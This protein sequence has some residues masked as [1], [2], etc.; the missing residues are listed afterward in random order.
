MNTNEL[1][2]K[3]KDHTLDKIDRMISSMKND[4]LSMMQSAMI[5][6]LKFKITIKEADDYILNSLAWQESK[7]SVEN[8]RNN[9]SDRINKIK[10][11]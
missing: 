5:L 7:K 3:Y 11:T 1:L 8:L 2:E 6:V 4:D 10:F 9:I